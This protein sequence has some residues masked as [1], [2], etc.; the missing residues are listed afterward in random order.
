MIAD[1]EMT[2]LNNRIFALGIDAWVSEGRACPAWEGYLSVAS[3][4]R[5]ILPSGDHLSMYM[6][7]KAHHTLTSLL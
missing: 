1:S 7:K 6:C 3:A 2:L 4:L 5:F